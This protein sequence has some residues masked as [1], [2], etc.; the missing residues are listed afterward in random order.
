MQISESSLHFC[1]AA[2][3]SYP[4]LSVVLPAEIS[5]FEYFIAGFPI[6]AFS[7]KISAWDV[8]GQ[9]S[10]YE[11][12]EQIQVRC[13]RESTGMDYT[14]YSSGQKKGV[15]KH[16]AFYSLLS[17]N[18][19]PCL[20]NLLLG[21]LSNDFISSKGPLS[22]EASSLWPGWPV[23]YPQLV[24]TFFWLYQCIFP[25]KVLNGGCLSVFFHAPLEVKV[26]SKP[27][28]SEVAYI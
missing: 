18:C 1:Y 11:T 20:D 5:N 10:R 15:W 26:S 22:G 13:R 17:K 2:T 21:G 8:G 4:E 14:F 28:A 27:A 19:S 7:S 6:N 25:K 16:L 3:K 12:E 9:I 24:I 23:L